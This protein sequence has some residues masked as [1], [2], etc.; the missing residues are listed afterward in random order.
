M[1][2]GSKLENVQSDTISQ[3]E[4]KTCIQKREQQKENSR[5]FSELPDLSLKG[6]GV[7]HDERST[8]NELDNV[9][10]KQGSH[11]DK[12]NQQREENQGRGGK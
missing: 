4:V 5:N 11:V 6:S 9:N 1:K 12:L 8:S 10:K 3:D 7:D 2:T